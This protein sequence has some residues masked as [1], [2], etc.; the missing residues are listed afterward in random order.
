MGE[1]ARRH[2]DCMFRVVQLCNIPEDLCSSCLQ[3]TKGKGG[4][5][6][7]LVPN[8]QGMFLIF[9][10]FFLDDSFLR[11]VFASCAREC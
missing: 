9:Q 8:I 1:E 10:M 7:D 6:L 3:T 4:R 11:R 2:S 5:G